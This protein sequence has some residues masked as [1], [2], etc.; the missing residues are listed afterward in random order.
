MILTEHTESGNQK[1]KKKNGKPKPAI[2]QF[3]RY[4]ARK[5]VL[6]VKKC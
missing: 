5:N 2:I 3:V 6:L 1:K 4:N